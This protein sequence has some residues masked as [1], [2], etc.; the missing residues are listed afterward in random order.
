MMG[1]GYCDWWEQVS[2]FN[3]ICTHPDSRNCGE[4]VGSSD[5]CG[6]WAKKS[7][8]VKAEPVE[9]KEEY[10]PD[11]ENLDPSFLIQFVR[12]NSCFDADLLAK[13]IEEW[14]QFKKLVPCGE[15]K[16][17]HEETGNCELN[18]YFVDDEGLCCSPA[19]SPCWTMWD[20]SEFCSRG[21]RKNDDH[22]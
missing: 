21:E 14:K 5:S 7:A 17:Y 22:S 11:P 16:H 13:I 19:E 20:K 8:P 18:S 10:V 4:Y 3:G 6:K 9:A 15:C 2:E 1:C 12:Q